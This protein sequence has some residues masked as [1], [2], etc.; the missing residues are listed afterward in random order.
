MRIVR[1][2]VAGERNP[3]VLATYRDVRCHSSAETIRAALVGNDREEHVFALSQALELYDTYQAKMLDCDRKLEALMSALS[4]KAAKPIGKLSRP[5]VKTKQVNTP[6][7][8]VW[9]ALYGI[10]GVDLTEIHGLGPSL[11]LK[12]VGECGT[13]LSAWS[14][15]KHFTSWLCLAPGNKISGGKLLSSRT[16]RLERGRFASRTGRLPGRHASR[17]PFEGDLAA[18]L[19]TSNAAGH[20]S[21]SLRGEKPSN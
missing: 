11:A 13:D 17:R 2:I 6:S 18:S 8:D 3:D 7:F 16:R 20:P 15:A 10:V 19:P 9:A 21:R 12:L 14:T 1:A 5:R 4:D